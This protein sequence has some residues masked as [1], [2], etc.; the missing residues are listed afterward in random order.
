M[1]ETDTAQPSFSK[2]ARDAFYV[3]S[4]GLAICTMIGFLGG[5]YWFFDLF[6]HFRP[7]YIPCA[8]ILAAAT[9]LLQLKKTVWLNLAMLFINAV[10]VT[11][12]LMPHLLHAP[13]KTPPVLTAISANIL[14]INRHY[15]FADALLQRFDADIFLMLETTEDWVQETAYLKERFPYFAAE[16]RPDNF[17]ILFF[18]KY[19]FDGGVENFTDTHNPAITFP[20]IRAEFKDTPLNLHDRPLVFYG[21]HT[22]P[23]VAKEYAVYRDALMAYIAAEIAAT[24]EKDIIVM[25]DLND[26][27]WSQN[28][29]NFLTASG[30]QAVG[31]GLQNT[32]PTAL[33]APLRLQID[34]AL[35]KGFDKF[36]SR[37]LTDTPMGSDH[38]PILLQIAP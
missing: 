24:P 2:L 16:A 1:T 4:I 9:C 25:G 17:G 34:H 10:I 13:P 6:S 3:A 27:V 5:T 38:L 21:I 30:L 20:Y 14:S 28:F 29:R 18:S 7:Y 8:V 32:W 26:T 19:S 33:P 12:I 35:I 36:S 31:T 15:H 22:T 37:M 11:T 23:P